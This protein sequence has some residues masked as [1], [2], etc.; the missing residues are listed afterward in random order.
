MGSSDFGFGRLGNVIG[1]IATFAA[2]WDGSAWTILPTPAAGPSP[3]LYSVSC[4]SPTFCVAVGYTRAGGRVTTVAG[5][6]PHALVEMWNGSAWTVTPTPLSSVRDSVLTGVSCVSSRFCTAVGAF[7]GS[8]GIAW[9]GSTWRRMTLP[10]VHYDPTLTAITCVA[11]NACTAVGS[12]SVNKTGVA[13]LRPLAAQWSGRHWT[14]D[15]PPPEY[16]RFHGKAFANN[17]WLTAVSCAARRSCLATGLAERTQNFY[18]NGG[19]GDRWDGRRWTVA[20]AGIARDSPLYDV[21]CVAA[22]DCYAAGQFDP[23][24]ITAPTTQRPLVEHWASG[25]WSSTALPPVA[26]LTNRVWFEGNLLNPN[27]NGISCVPQSG[28]VA[29]GAQPQ[30]AASAPLALTDL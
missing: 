16:D 3:A 5:R 22:D 25:R 14:V 10:P 20:T 28:C 17:T 23:H 11:A 18:P 27:L 13:Q 8:W 24:T 4:A 2:H 12:Y 9:N 19:F 30:G 6:N 1:P 26:T 15:R 21:S 29:V 7:L